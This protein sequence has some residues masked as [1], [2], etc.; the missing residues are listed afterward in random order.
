MRCRALLWTSR[1]SGGLDSIPLLAQRS[2]QTR[3]NRGGH[4]EHA[5]GECEHARSDG[6]EQDT[7][8]DQSDDRR[9]RAAA[10]GV[11]LHHSL[12]SRAGGLEISASSEAHIS[13]FPSAMPA[14]PANMT[15]G[16]L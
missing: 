2:P 16:L 6:F 14:A 10:R 7:A 11:A 1:T 8:E 15:A 4:E 13:P 3:R 9:Q 12:I 5:A